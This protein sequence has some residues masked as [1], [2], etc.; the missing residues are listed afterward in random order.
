ME[1][2]NLNAPLT[3][4]AP[5]SR[6][7]PPV[8]E[9]VAEGRMRGKRPA[10]IIHYHQFYRAIQAPTMMLTGLLHWPTCASSKR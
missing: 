6:P 10:S 1:N 2:L 8:G 9:K 5:S 3:A 4:S 7:S